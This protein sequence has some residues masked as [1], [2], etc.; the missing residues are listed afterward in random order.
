MAVGNEARRLH[1]DKIEVD[2]IDVD[3][4]NDDTM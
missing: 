4:V 1:V 3:E 2:K